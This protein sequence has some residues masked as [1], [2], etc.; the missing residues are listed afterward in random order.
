M[1]YLRVYWLGKT[2]G[3]LGFEFLIKKLCVRNNDTYSEKKQQLYNETNM[4][5]ITEKMPIPTC[6]ISS[7]TMGHLKK[8]QLN[9]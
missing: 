8:I 7:L 5:N 3:V 2:F 9:L 6:V 4:R 1:F